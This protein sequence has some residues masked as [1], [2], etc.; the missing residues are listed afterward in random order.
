[1]GGGLTSGCLKRWG[2]GLGLVWLV[3][4]G[5]SHLWRWARPWS[6]TLGPREEAIEVALPPPLA[7]DLERR[8]VRVV[9]ADLGDPTDPVPVVLLHGSPGSSGNFRRLV[10]SLSAQRRYLCVDLPGFGASERSLGDY[11]IRTQ[12]GIL[13]ECLEELGLSQVHLVGYS[14]GGGV[15]LEVCRSDPDRVRSL[16]LLSSIG[17]QE[18][19]L[20]GDYHV[21][22]ALHGAQVALLWLVHGLIPHFG[23]FDG[24][25][26]SVE[27]ARN[28]YDSDQRPL[29]ADLLSW[30]G[31]LLLLHGR[32]DALAPFAVAEESQRLAPQ[33]ELVALE[34]GHLLVFSDPDRL[35]QPLTEFWEAAEAGEAP[36][37]ADVAPELRA[38]SLEPFD[39]TGVPPLGG[40]ALLIFFAV[41]VLATLVSEDL[42]CVAVGALVG[43]GR[44]GLAL[45]AGA[46]FLGIYVGDLLLFLAGR[47]FGRRAVRRAPLKW[48]LTEE[49]VERSSAWFQSR[50]AWVI[51]MSRF[52]P[53]AR[54]PTYFAAGL[55]RTSLTWFALWFALAAGIWTPVVVWISSLL[56]GTLTER[57]S[58]LRE[59]GLWALVLTVVLGLFLVRVVIPLATHR[60]RRL[61]YGAWLRKTRWE[62]WPR[63]AVYLPV[64]M[65]ALWEGLR[66]GRPLAFT[67]CNPGMPHAGFVGESKAQILRGLRDAGD[68]LPAWELIP[69]DAP[70]EQ[71]LEA[72]W[73]VQGGAQ[74]TWPVVVKPDVGER[75][76]GVIVARS[77]EEVLAA[78]MG[79]GG[80][81]ILQAFAPGP[82]FGLFWAHHP[83][84]PEGHILSVVEKRL[85]FVIGDGVRSLEDLILDD[86]RAVA[87]APFF[88]DR[89]RERLGEVPAAGQAV[90]IGELGTH[91]KGALFLDGRRLVSPELTAAVAQVATSFVAQGAGCGDRAGFSFGRLDVRCDSEEALR[92]GRFAIIEVNGVTSEAAHI[93]DPRYGP[94]HGWRTLAAQ[95]RLAQ[96]IG[97]AHARRGAPT[98]GPGDLLRAVLSW[99]REHGSLRRRA[100]EPRS[101]AGPNSIPQS[102]NPSGARTSG[103]CG[104]ES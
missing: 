75:G 36:L 65:A 92:A 84:E 86:D 49:R 9:F 85:P 4:L 12:A 23:A 54:L 42:T 62:Y 21:N 76:D 81:V 67:A 97:A 91:C 7:E 10:A 96:H 24:G 43:Q 57:V 2:L 87:L 72:L 48:F 33:A 27:Y 74:R 68:R 18:L 8:S 15:A 90:R 25:M 98:S 88:L 22:H 56:S 41:V 53:G 26:L 63:W 104:L 39:P 30:D 40:V 69:K 44:V 6:P 46:C 17:V 99:R 80:D 93:Y 77:P 29:R 82:E 95:W 103:D 52:L 19:E 66:L 32:G 20:F 13:L 73:R 5:A 51:F 34:G 47:W 64:G 1:M 14:M 59:N 3:L 83:D 45:G 31:P 94:W 60:G 71:V 37:R 16:T 70:G 50:G 79:L 102:Q 89:N 61:L 28:F 101:F 100:Q 11:S 55:L 58:F 78:A 38:R 35:A